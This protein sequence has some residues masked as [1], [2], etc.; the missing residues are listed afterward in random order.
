MRTTILGYDLERFDFVSA[1]KDALGAD[2]LQAL[3]HDEILSR[4][5]DQHTELHRT[6]YAR[7]AQ[8]GRLYREFVAEMARRVFTGRPIYYQS[9][10]TFRVQF[11][12]NVAVGEF[13]RDR[14][15][16][17]QQGEI[18]FWVPVTPAFGTNTVWIEAE[19]FDYL[20]QRLGPGQ[21]LIFDGVNLLHGNQ[22]NTTGV[23]RVSFDFRIIAQDAF[24]PMDALSVSAG[25]R[26]IVGDYWSRL[27]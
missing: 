9:V 20:P 1:V 23:S 11:P 5:T 3:R 14:D 24:R 15:Y 10:P 26:M 2:D 17:H 18:N 25:K 8:M 12:D 21:V 7:F 4:G 6:F 27:W 13:H 22:V 16:H 19:G